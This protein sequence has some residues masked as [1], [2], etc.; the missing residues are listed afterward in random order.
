MQTRSHIMH[1]AMIDLTHIC[2]NVRC[3]VLPHNLSQHTLAYFGCDAFLWFILQQCHVFLKDLPDAS[4]WVPDGS[5]WIPD[6][7]QMIPRCPLIATWGP[8]CG[9][10]CETKW[11]LATLPPI[12]L[13]NMSWLHRIHV[14]IC[15]Y[16][17]AWTCIYIYICTH[18]YIYICIYMYYTTFFCV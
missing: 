12:L 5:R 14:S 18:M 6:A 13:S 11:E 2:C 8:P 10:P 7:S 9:P 16:V 4:R 17:W 3:V 1:D 15:T